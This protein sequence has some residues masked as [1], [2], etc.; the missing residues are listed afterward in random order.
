MYSIIII[1]N[2]RIRQT[3]FHKKRMPIIRDKRRS[4]LWVYNP[5]VKDINR[6]FGII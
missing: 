4:G 6:R 1:A 2:P 5:V 3:K